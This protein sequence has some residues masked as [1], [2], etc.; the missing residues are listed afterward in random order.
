MCA[1]VPKLE[2]E[3]TQW[4]MWHGWQGWDEYEYCTLCSRW[5]W[6]G[7]H[8]NTDEHKYNV[9]VHKWH[10]I[11][12]MGPGHRLGGPA[13]CDDW[14]CEWSRWSCEWNADYWTWLHRR[15]ELCETCLEPC[16]GVPGAV[17]RQKLLLTGMTRE[18]LE[19]YALDKVVCA[20]S[21]PACRTAAFAHI[22]VL[23]GG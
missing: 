16:N 12:R 3:F 17:Q 6:N 20:W 22:S 4:R 2:P 8:A 23:P 19:S 14:T 18:E 11:D 9:N 1:F 13:R 7:A 21:C 15:T 5:N 10:K